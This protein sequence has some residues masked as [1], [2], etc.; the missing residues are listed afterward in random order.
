[1]CIAVFCS[2]STAPHAG[3]DDLYIWVE[4]TGGNVIFSHEG[5]IDLM[6]FGP[7][8]AAAS[9]GAVIN[10]SFGVYYGNTSATADNYAAMPD[11]STRTYGTGFLANPDSATGDFFGFNAATSLVLPTGYV[12]APGG[13]VKVVHE[14]NT[15][16]F[17][18]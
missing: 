6:G 3:A 5:S 7:V 13:A 12:I 2:L 15:D 16:H 1:M 9:F 4:E 10:P 14:L 18:A 8:L 11:G 17:Y